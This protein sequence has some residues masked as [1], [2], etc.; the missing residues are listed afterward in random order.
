MEPTPTPQKTIAL[1]GR[2]YA[3][4]GDLLSGEVA[5]MP[6]LS[7]FLF[8]GNLPP[9]LPSTLTEDQIQKILTQKLTDP[10]IQHRLAYCL[11]VYVPGLAEDGLV[12]Y[13]CTEGDEFGAVRMG[14]DELLQ[15]VSQL[16]GEAIPEIDEATAK[17]NKEIA[18]L[19][20]QR[21]ELNRKL[22]ELQQ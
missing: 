6:L 17:K 22:A 12:Q 4:H 8:D 7:L 9:A 16:T 2:T 14:G 18:D 5:A 3:V 19:E 20:R 15:L 11:R 21:E 1:R 13:S 10:K